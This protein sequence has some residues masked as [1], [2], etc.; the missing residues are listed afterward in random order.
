MLQKQDTVLVWQHFFK[1]SAEALQIC[2][3]E[4]I[5]LPAA[6]KAENIG[7]GVWLITS[8]TTAYTLIETDT[9]S[10]T[11]SEIIKYPGSKICIVTL[12]CGK[13]LVG[14]HQNSIRPKNMRTAF[15]NQSKSKTSAPIG[16]I[17]E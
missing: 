15:S 14:P 13:Q 6:K 4:Q 1:G 10:A 11:S 17:M 16:R 3:T 9:A 2:A 5:L 12:E 8:A 7:I